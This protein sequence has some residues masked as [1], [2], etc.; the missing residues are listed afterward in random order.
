MV[1]DPIVEAKFDAVQQLVD[2]RDYAGARLILKGIDDPTAR[3]WERK[4]DAL[5]PP[6]KLSNWTAHLIISVIAF[7]IGGV[8]LIVFFA[9]FFDWR[10][11][12]SVRSL[13]IVLAVAGFAVAFVTNKLGKR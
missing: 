8:A 4:I 2:T 6:P 3:E 5:H 13:A 12:Y 1:Q 11:D 10:I 9:T 7:A